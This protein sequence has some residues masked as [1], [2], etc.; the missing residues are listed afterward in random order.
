MKPTWRNSRKTRPAGESRSS[1]PKALAIGRHPEMWQMRVSDA[2]RLSRERDAPRYTCIRRK[3]DYGEPVCQSLA[4]NRL[5]AVVSEQVLARARTGVS[6]VSLKAAED[7]EKERARLHRHWKQQLERGRDMRNE[8]ATVRSCGT[9][10]SIG[11][12]GT[13]EPMGA[14]AGQATPNG[15][16]VARFQRQQPSRLSEDERN[17]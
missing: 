15:R 3:V 4:G 1:P 13:R 10:E 6:G 11:G 2:R 9:G 8:Q 5:E 14:I 7:I 16:R 12:S 17:Q